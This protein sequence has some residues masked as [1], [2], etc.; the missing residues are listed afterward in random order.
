M[1]AIQLKAKKRGRPAIYATDEERKAA[2]RDKNAA[3]FA[4]EEYKKRR[5]EKYRLDKAY[6]L[7]CI[8]KATNYAASK[9]QAQA[10]EYERKI[11]ANLLNMD[12]IS[13]VRK[14]SPRFKARPSSVTMRTLTIAEFATLINRKAE[15]V[16][17]WVT[18]NKLPPPSWLDVSN[19]GIRCYSELQ[20]VEMAR[21]IMTILKTSTAHFVESNKIAIKL[22]AKT[23]TIY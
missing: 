5:R 10:A 2:R 9:K 20:A 1:T 13:K 8:K 19:R 4:S 16:R 18:A 22:L 15:V 23:T 21:I 14:V 6:R 12:K 11:K 7:E 17:D 3:Y